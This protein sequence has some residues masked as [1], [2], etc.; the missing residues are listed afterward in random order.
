MNFNES[1][2]KFGNYLGYILMFF[3]FT[4]IF[5]LILSILKKLPASWTYFH[6]FAISLLLV[7]T[8]KT[9]KFW[10]DK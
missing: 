2:T 6:V 1:K 9:I 8:G 5:F 4:F 10:L 7:L 3:A